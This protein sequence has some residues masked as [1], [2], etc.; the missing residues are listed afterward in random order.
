MN[1]KNCCCVIHSHQ[2]AVDQVIRTFQWIAKN[3][4]HIKKTG[5]LNFHRIHMMGW[6]MGGCTYAFSSSIHAVLRGTVGARCRCQILYTRMESRMLLYLA[7][8]GSSGTC[9]SSHS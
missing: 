9:G 5:T 8:T 3:S 6:L 2:I 7:T 4:S 1:M